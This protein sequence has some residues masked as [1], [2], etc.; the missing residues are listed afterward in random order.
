[1]SPS[2]NENNYMKARYIFQTPKA[3]FYVPQSP[4]RHTFTHTDTLTKEVEKTR[5]KYFSEIK[6][7]LWLVF[8]GWK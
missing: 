4:S 3:S 2:T 7:G 1:M 5:T 8:V 6:L